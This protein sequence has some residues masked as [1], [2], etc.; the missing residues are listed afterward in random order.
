MKVEGERR[1][2]YVSRPNTFGILILLLYCRSV[3]VNWALVCCLLF[4]NLVVKLTDRLPT[5]VEASWITL[6][7]TSGHKKR[8]RFAKS[9]TILYTPR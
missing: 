4:P 1:P 9:L 6:S 2:L 3:D 8:S 7:F 5:P